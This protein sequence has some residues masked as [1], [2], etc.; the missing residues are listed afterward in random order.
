MRKSIKIS[1]EWMNE[2]GKTSEKEKQRI[3]KTKQKQT[4]T[5]S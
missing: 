2:Y 1:N 3:K 5:H 4:N